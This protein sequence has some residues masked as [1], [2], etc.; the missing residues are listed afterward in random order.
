MGA[1]STNSFTFAL[2][3][4]KSDSS[5]YFPNRTGSFEVGDKKLAQ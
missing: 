2:Y 3:F 5:G 4:F 1:A